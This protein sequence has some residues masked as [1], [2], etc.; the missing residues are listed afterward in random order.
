MRDRKAAAVI[1]AGLLLGYIFVFPHWLDWNANARLD[2]SAAIVEQGTLTIDAYAQNTGDYALFNGQRYSDKAPGLSFLGVPAYFIVSR[3]T[4]PEP[5][6]NLIS[7]LG[8]SPA[9]ALTI[10]RPIDLVSTQEFV[11]ASRTALTTWLVVGVP[12]AMLGVVLFNFLGRMKYPARRRALA[13]LIY[14]FATPAFAYSAA[15]YGHQ[16]AAVMLFS[17]FTWLHALRTR[18]AR[19]IE[20]LLVGSLLGYAV[21]TEYP[22]VLIAFIIGLYGLWIARRLRPLTL[23]LLGG[24]IPIGLWGIYD[25][26]IF[27]TPLVLGYQYTADPTWHA[28]LS[29]GFLSASWPTLNAVWGLTFSPFRGLFFGSPILLLAIPGLILLRRSSHRAEWLVTLAVSI[30]FLLLVSASA[31]WWGGW[32]AGPRYLIPMLP[33]LIWPLTATLDRM[34]Q[35]QA[36]RRSM[37]RTAGL[38]LAGASFIVVGSLTAGGQYY[39]PDDISNPLVQYSWPHLAAGDVA[40]NLGMLMGL[41]G[42]TSLLPLMAIVAI[43]FYLI[44]QVTKTQPSAA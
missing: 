25:T 9:A 20:W 16:V 38:V 36:L 15:F 24:L 29:T 37:L 32:A 23:M 22:A 13:V 40:R 42:A 8:R 1:F 5:V 18:H 43:T 35:A 21:I 44:W 17:A 14:G 26:A 28:I 34:E 31:Q 41:P 10:H 6:Q 27:G 11:F 2:L 19:S 33:F 4:H 30:G 39:A 7:A 3:L 12:S